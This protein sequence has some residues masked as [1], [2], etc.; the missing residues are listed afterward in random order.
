MT[1]K[2]DPTTKS[3]NEYV[4][5]IEKLFRNNQLDKYIRYA[6][7]PNFKNLAHGDRIDFEYPLTAIIGPNGSGKSSILH[8]LYGMPYKSSTSRFW[9]STTLDPIQEGKDKGPNRYFYSHLIRDLSKWVETKKVRGRK[10]EA[11]WEPARVSIPDGMSPMPRFDPKEAEYRSKDRW[12]PVVRDPIYISFKYHFSAFDRIYHIN[13]TKLSLASKIEQVKKGAEKLSRV[14]E[15]DKQSFKPGGVEAVYEHRNLTED[16]LLWVNYILGKQYLEARYIEHRLY[17]K[18]RGSSVIFHCNQDKYSE[19]FAGSGELAIVHLVV[20][21]INSNRNS[22]ILLDEPETSL[23]PGAQEKL[24]K[25]LLSEIVNKHLQVILTTHSPTIANCLPS[26]AL[27]ALFEVDNNKTTVTDV[28]HPQMA[29]NRIG[30]APSDKKLIIV[31]DSLLSA[32]VDVAIDELE[33]WEQEIITTQIPSSGGDDVFKNLVPFFMQHEQSAHFILDGDKV[34]KQQIDYENLDSKDSAALYKIIKESY[35]CKP[36]YLKEE[37]KSACIDYLLWA[38]ERVHYLNSVCPEAVFLELLNIDSTG[39]T[40]LQA[41]ERLVQYLDK[42]KLGSDAST[43]K[44]LFNLYLRK[45]KTNKY[46]A[47][48]TSIL[49]QICSA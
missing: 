8:A 16:E 7:F 48:I 46:V 4:E 45:D 26:K 14:I 33:E 1:S 23:H 37:N 19:A 13:N 34:A 31:E 44:T 39:L 35:D 29:F 28:Q 6:V 9:F 25:F 32:I 27:K 2:K 11:Y 36:L 20:S 42:E 10:N 12:N 15:R 3:I 24:I 41:K 17:G 40:N 30:H 43:Q 21:L 22:L 47:H 18:E 5:I 49:K 38:R